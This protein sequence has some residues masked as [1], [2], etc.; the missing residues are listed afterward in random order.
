MVKGGLLSSKS[1]GIPGEDEADRVVDPPLDD[2][3][4]SPLSPPGASPASSRRRGDEG[5]IADAVL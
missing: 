4:E 3:D 5:D 2:R 1:G